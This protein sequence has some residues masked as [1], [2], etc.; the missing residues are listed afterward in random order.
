MQHRL[1]LRSD[2][3]RWGLFALITGLT[4]PFVLVFGSTRGGDK[5]SLRGRLDR[6]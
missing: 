5:R 3:V 1:A 2:K 4:L 6:R